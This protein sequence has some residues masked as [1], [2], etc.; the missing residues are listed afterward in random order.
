MCIIFEWGIFTAFIHRSHSFK[1]RFL[2]FFFSRRLRAIL[3]SLHSTF[4]AHI[5]WC[6]NHSLYEHKHIERNTRS[7][8]SVVSCTTRKR[9]VCSPGRSLWTF[10]SLCFTCTNEWN[11]MK[12]KKNFSREKEKSTKRKKKK[13]SKKYRMIQ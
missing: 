3:F 12:C 4:Y 1:I 6:Q 7:Y 2:I 9:A 5:S 8:R 10:S 11:K 13:K